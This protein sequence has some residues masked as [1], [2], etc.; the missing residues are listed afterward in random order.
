[1]ISDKVKEILNEQ[2]NKEFYSAYLYLSMGAYMSELGLYGISRWL[3]V[4]SREEIDHGMILFE[5][6]NKHKAKVILKSINAPEIEYSNVKE[7]FE[8]IYNHERSITNAI[9][10]IAKLAENE[11]DM[12]TRN[13]ID[14]YLKEQVEEED[15]ALRI[16]S[17]LQTFGYEGSALYLMDEELGKVEYSYNSPS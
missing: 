4:Q 2:I 3:E 9:D 11:C 7:M 17:R 6:L 8:K 1:M 14:W 16:L 15:C 12:A 13:F 5:Y 10:E